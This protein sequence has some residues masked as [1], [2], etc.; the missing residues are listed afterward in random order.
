MTELLRD[1]FKES[2]RLG[3][4]PAERIMLILVAALA[5][6]LARRARV[7]L[8]SIKLTVEAQ[9]LVDEGGVVPPSTQEFGDPAS[10]GGDSY[11]G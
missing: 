9:P 10:P 5:L 6:V 11:G 8:G 7:A 1:L 2:A 4:A 3:L